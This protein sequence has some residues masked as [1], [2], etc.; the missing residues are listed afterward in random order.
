MTSIN[1][2]YKDRD[3]KETVKKIWDFFKSENLKIN[4]TREC[5]T[6]GNT[7]WCSAE[8]LNT[9]NEVIS[10][11]N[12]KG[13]TAE[14]CLA[15]CF[16]EMYERYC[17]MLPR[18]FF[19]LY[20][21]SQKSFKENGYYIAPDEILQNVNEV[22]N[23]SIR[24]KAFFNMIE[25]NNH[26]YFKYHT[27]IYNNKE[28]LPCVPFYNLLN[29]EDIKYLN[30]N[31]ISRFQGSSGLA[32]GNSLEEALVQG[33][34]EVFEHHVAAQLY[35]DIQD[36]YYRLDL[37]KLNLSD[38]L[39][40]IVNTITNKYDLQIFDLS[41]NFNLPVLMSVL[42][43]KKTHTWSVD[44]ASA[45]VFEIALE[46]SL[47]ELY[48]GF[49]DFDD[50]SEVKVDMRPNRALT[51]WTAIGTRNQAT[52]IRSFYPEEILLKQTIIDNY[53]TSI[54]LQSND[55]TNENLYNYYLD[56]IKK[57]NLQIYLRNISKTQGIFTIRLYFECLDQQ[58]WKYDLYKNFEKNDVIKLV[59]SQSK[60]CIEY[61]NYIENKTYNIDNM[62]EYGKIFENWKNK[63]IDDEKTYSFYSLDLC[64]YQLFNI[65]RIFLFNSNS[66]YTF[67][68]WFSYIKTNITEHKD[69]INN[70][71]LYYITL[72]RY[73]DSNKYTKKEIKQ[74]IEKLGFS[75]DNF[76]NDYNGCDNIKY[77][78]E[79][80][81]I[82]LID[83]YYNSDS[84][85]G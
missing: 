75:I 6:N 48:Q 18:G 26:D 34:S 27:K 15:S 67:F 83:I 55:Y 44:I 40:N 14:F 72:F 2:K 66:P 28:L 35:Y 61:L 24:I 51:P 43:N 65:F 57:N 23:S 80:I 49:S 46:R 54:F 79:H 69:I 10:R 36:T 38:Y 9:K 52:T 47:T 8:L 64:I 25:D 85:V 32:A 77:L 81:I 5:Q 1:N 37:N 7:F 73:K 63:Y 68:Q 3:P 56:I 21:Q 82:Y 84:F 78:I 16:S 42:L 59:S 45:P 22:Y 41:Y 13:T 74:I 53:N 62:I 11:S 20:K 19:T 31:L 4:I 60:L 39:Q 71:Y 70:L 58:R 50:I 29:K 33:I 12:G 17:S 76:E 30:P